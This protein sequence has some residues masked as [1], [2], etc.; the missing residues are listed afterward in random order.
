M[1]RVTPLLANGRLVLHYH[2]DLD[3]KMQMLCNIVLSSG[4]Y[5]IQDT[6]GNLLNTNTEANNV[7]SIFAPIMSAASS[8]ISWQLQLFSGGAYVLEDE[9]SL[10][11]V[12]SAGT[13]AIPGHMNTFVFIDR[14]NIHVRLR[15]MGAAFG[16][17]GHFGASQLSGAY[18][19][20]EAEFSNTLVGHLG[21][22]WTGRSANPPRHFVALT[23]ALNRKSRRRLGMV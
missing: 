12:G 17:Y 21:A 8:F 20:I 2:T 18:A 11:V 16:S 9:G 13:A 10:S 5:H 23:T 3:H 14:L 1:A 22:W 7:G 15:Q 4:V 19:A 6:Y